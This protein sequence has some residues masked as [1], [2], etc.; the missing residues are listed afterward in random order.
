MY[1]SFSD[2]FRAAQAFGVINFIGGCVVLV[3][4]LGYL[5][6]YNIKRD[7]RLITIT[8]VFRSFMRESLVLVYVDLV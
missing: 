1:I 7:P 8:G 3:F 2:G 4:S 6:T 5:L